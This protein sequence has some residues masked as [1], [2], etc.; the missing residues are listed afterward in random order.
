MSCDSIPHERRENAPPFARS[1]FFR[2]K[3]SFAKIYESEY[4]RQV[5]KDCNGS[6]G[7]REKWDIYIF[8]TR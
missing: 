4:E 7:S 6:N 3:L 2:I 1:N 8:L 5:V